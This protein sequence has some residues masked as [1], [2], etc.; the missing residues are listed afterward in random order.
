[1]VLHHLKGYAESIGIWESEV[2]KGWFENDEDDSAFL[3]RANKFL[4]VHVVEDGIQVVNHVVKT[5]SY[6]DFW[7]MSKLVSL[8]LFEYLGLI[9]RSW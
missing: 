3:L 6:V 8:L 4:R 1:M 7:F 9:P 5:Q 2:V